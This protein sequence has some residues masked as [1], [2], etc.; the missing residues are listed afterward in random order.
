MFSRILL[1][2]VVIGGLW[3]LLFGLS[4]RDID[5]FKHWR[6][7]WLGRF[8]SVERTTESGWKSIK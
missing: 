2:L 1:F 6:H 4:D 3:L 8:H 5:G 7:V